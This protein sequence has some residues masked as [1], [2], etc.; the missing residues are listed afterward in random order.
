MSTTVLALKR[1]TKRFYQNLPK[2]LQER[3]QC[4]RMM[5]VPVASICPINSRVLINLQFRSVGSVMYGHG[6]RG[7]YGCP[8]LWEKY[9][10]G[11]Q[12]NFDICTAS[13]S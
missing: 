1:E 2:G 8:V 9:V 4:G 11:I 10:F 7:L 3:N 13:A 6:Q 12:S 5:C